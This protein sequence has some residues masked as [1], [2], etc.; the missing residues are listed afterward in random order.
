MHCEDLPTGGL[1][2][3]AQIHLPPPRPH[4]EGLYRVIALGGGVGGRR[5][6]GSTLLTHK[7]H[8]DKTVK[9]KLKMP[10]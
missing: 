5:G 3:P 4:V 8:I 10:V 6:G 9:T 1:R 2:K 7:A